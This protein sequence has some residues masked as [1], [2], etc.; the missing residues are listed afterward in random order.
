MYYAAAMGGLIPV[1]PWEI[2]N[3]FSSNDR[4][5]ALVIELEGKKAGRGDFKDGRDQGVDRLL[6]KWQ[7]WHLAPQ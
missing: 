5:A 7:R 3:I 2:L 4:T 1:G 6:R